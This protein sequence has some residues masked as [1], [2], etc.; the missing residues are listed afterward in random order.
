MKNSY[1]VEHRLIL[2]DKCVLISSE[3][4]ALFSKVLKIFT[5]VNLKSNSSIFTKM[6]TR[7]KVKLLPENLT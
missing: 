7:V 2:K 1:Y 3:N 6:F 4:Y 5:Q